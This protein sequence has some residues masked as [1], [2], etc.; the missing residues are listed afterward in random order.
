MNEPRLQP[1]VGSDDHVLGPADAP[2][3]LVE[4]G[5]FQCPYCGQAYPI[6]KAVQ[7][8]LGDDLRFVFRHFP[9]TEMHPFA[10]HAAEAAEAAGAQ[11][12]FW[13]M[14]DALYEHQSRLD[15]PALVRYAAALGLD[16]DRVA[17][18]L[19][20]GTYA[21]RVQD[22]FLSGVRSGVNGTPT[23]FVN[24]A[25]FDGDWTDE[26]TFLRALRAAALARRS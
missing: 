15:D 16:A 18:A 24:G 12:H 3:T 21:Q 23:F 11:G 17:R 4:Y 14:H 13:A 7:Q 19:E 25:R 2:V 6:V 8:R 1:A 10:Q 26:A 22:D 9:L 5:D 20:E